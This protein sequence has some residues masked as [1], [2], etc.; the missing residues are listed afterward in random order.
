[1][2]LFTAVG[3]A[4]TSDAIVSRTFPHDKFSNCQD[5][6]VCVPRARAYQPCYAQAL[7]SGCPARLPDFTTVYFPMITSPHSQ[8]R[9]ARGSARALHVSEQNAPRISRKYFGRVVR[10]PQ[11]VQLMAHPLCRG[12]PSGL[13]LKW[14]TITS[15]HTTQRSAAGSA[16]APQSSLQNAP[17]IPVKY[18]GCSVARPHCSHG[19]GQPRCRTVPF[20]HSTYAPP[21]AMA[22]PHTKQDGVEPSLLVAGRAPELGV[23]ASCLRPRTASMS[24]RSPLD[25]AAPPPPPRGASPRVLPSRRMGNALTGPAEGPRR[26]RPMSAPTAEDAGTCAVCGRC[27]GRCGPAVRDDIDARLALLFPP[28]AY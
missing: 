23:S 2:H 9:I 17:G 10:R 21:G 7:C 5:V 4:R 13:L 6:C 25:D 28:G 26:R 22:A 12:S 19:T 20:G 15:L 18:R 8:H 24:P 27:R 11:L 16:R 3:G 1:L 14:P